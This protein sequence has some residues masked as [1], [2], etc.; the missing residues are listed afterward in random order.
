MGSRLRRSGGVWPGK[1]GLRINQ[2]V[3]SVSWKSTMKWAPASAGGLRTGPRKAATGCAILRL[4][5]PLR[6]RRRFSGWSATRTHRVNPSRSAAT[7][8]PS[9]WR[10]RSASRKTCGPIPASSTSSSATRMSLTS[11]RWRIAR[12]RSSARRSAPRACR[13]MPRARSWSAFSTLKCPTTSRAWLTS[14]AGASPV[15][16]FRLRP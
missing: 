11:I 9:W 7:I 1:S 2:G 15:R 13:S 14:C 12:C 8:A 5:W 10:C 4:L 6:S 3:G 16:K